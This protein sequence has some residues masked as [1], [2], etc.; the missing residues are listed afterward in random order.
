MS[1]ADQD[2]AGLST[3][4]KGLLAAGVVV[5][6]WSGFNI[7][8]RAGTTGA[9][10]PYDIAALRFGVSG[11]LAL[12]FFLRMVPLAQYPRY[13]V[14]AMLAGVS[15][16]L[17]AYVGF[18][19]APTA[20][21]GVFINGGIPF[22]TVIIIA[23]TAGFQL[24]AR[25]L[26][27]LGFSAAGLLLIAGRSLTEVGVSNVWIGDLLFLSAALVWAVFGVLARR[28]Q[29]PPRSAIVGIAV[30]SLVAYMPVYLLCLP[31]NITM[32]PTNEILLQAGYQG[33]VA[34][35]VAGAMYTYACQTIGVYRASMTLAIVPGASALGA[36][37][38]LDEPLTAMVVAGLVLVSL[39]ALLAARR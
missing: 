18:S 3:H 19:Y 30:F 11:L 32:A 9:L 17:L 31:Q 26:V 7:V 4:T 23:V 25:S 28:W 24:S 13:F 34:A 1:L 36:W 15:Y 38:L 39:G 20:H 37:L 21:A 22:W 2:Q 14:L 10:T 27:P 12:P 5:L 35:L 33:V 8:S 29:V 16:S 6:C